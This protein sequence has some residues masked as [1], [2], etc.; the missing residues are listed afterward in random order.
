[1]PVITGQLPN[2]DRSKADVYLCECANP[3]LYPNTLLI[4]DG[5]TNCQTEVSSGT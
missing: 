2:S 4:V 3:I 1:M 5:N